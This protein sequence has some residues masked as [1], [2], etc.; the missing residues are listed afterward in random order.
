MLSLR[1]RVGV[2]KQNRDLGS[3]QEEVMLE[4]ILE[5]KRSQKKG[6]AHM[7]EREQ[8]Q[9]MEMCTVTLVVPQGGTGSADGWGKGKMRKSR[10][11]QK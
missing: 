8:Q 1:C 5:A 11:C 9:M 4:L 2:S 6:V 10:E 3:F 7:S